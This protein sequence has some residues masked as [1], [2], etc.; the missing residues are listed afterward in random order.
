MEVSNLLTPV[1]LES[2]APPKIPGGLDLPAFGASAAGLL[3]FFVTLLQA[4]TRHAIIG[5]GIDGGIAF[6][7]EGAER[8]FGYLPEEVIG[9]SNLALLH[10]GGDGALGLADNIFGV[11]ARDRFLSGQAQWLRKS[12]ERFAAHAMIVPRFDAKYLLVGYLVILRPLNQ[13]S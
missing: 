4:S 8:L 2:H 7:D 10:A 1:A 12:G 5:L 3:E 11:A 9:R 6:W 13:V